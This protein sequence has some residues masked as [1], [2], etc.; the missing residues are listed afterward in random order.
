MKTLKEIINFIEDKVA[1]SDNIIDVIKES[2]MSE[3]WL[4]R[5]KAHNQAFKS[6]LE[7]INKG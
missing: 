4:I 1:K 7:F 5:A 3:E 2:G 6:V